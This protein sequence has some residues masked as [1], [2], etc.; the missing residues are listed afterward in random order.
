MLLA[1]RGTGTLETKGYVSSLHFI[2]HTCPLRETLGITVCL[3]LIQFL[4]SNES[5]NRY[6]SCNNRSSSAMPFTKQPPWSGGGGG[7]GSTRRRASDN[8]FQPMPVLGRLGP[9]SSGISTRKLPASSFD[10]IR[11]ACEHYERKC[12][13]GGTAAARHL[14]DLANEVRTLVDT[15]EQ[16]HLQATTQPHA[17]TASNVRHSWL[18][19]CG[20]HCLVWFMK[21]DRSL[22]HIP[23]LYAAQIHGMA[24]MLRPRERLRRSGL[25]CLIDWYLRAINS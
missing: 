21:P 25:Y 23:S 14:R 5:I 3:P 8:D 20:W 10:E 1:Q 6:H 15:L 24:A 17:W 22:S 9:L 4:T 2:L 19:G 11:K 18:V 16:E 7:G 12:P 13:S